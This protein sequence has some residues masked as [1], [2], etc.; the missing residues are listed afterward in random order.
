MIRIQRPT[1]SQWIVLWLG[2]IW[3]LGSL[4]VVDEYVARAAVGGL[5]VTL[6]LY[7]Q[8]S[9]WDESSAPTAA[10]DTS[11][12]SRAVPERVN[13]AEFLGDLLAVGFLS[14]G[15]G[16]KDTDIGRLTAGLSPELQEPAAS[17]INIYGCWL[18]RLAVREKYG[19]DF[20]Q[21]TW[22]AATRHVERHLG[23]VGQAERLRELARGVEM[24]DRASKSIGRKIGD[25]IVD[26]RPDIADLELP[27]AMPVAWSFLALSS[28]SPYEGE[29]EF[30]NSVDFQLAECLEAAR[31]AMLPTIRLLVEFDGP[32]SGTVEKAAQAFADA[33]HRAEAGAAAAGGDEELA[34]EW[35]DEPGPAERH[36]RRQQGNLLFPTERRIVSRAQLEVAQQQD[37]ASFRNL[38]EGLRATFEKVLG[39]PDSASMDQR[40]E[41]LDELDVLRVQCLAL[42]TA[43]AIRWLPD[44]D[45]SAAGT[46][47]AMRGS[48]AGSAEGSAAFDRWREHVRLRDEVS[49]NVA[50]IEIQQ[51]PTEDTVP[52][53]CSLDPDDI[54]L[55]L[56]TL[57]SDRTASES[58]RT[59]CADLFAKAVQEGFSPEKASA[60][61]RALGV[62]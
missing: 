46:L 2:A 43:D 10:A 12:T 56:R 6:L 27:F 17:W 5:I 35:S 1:R 21:A 54:A 19:E 53:V 47:D 55:L 20:A 41:A 49:H 33:V 60:R 23:G 45:S 4:A 42:A 40:K 61:L 58:L 37:Q 34:L 52:T 15:F 36:L 26:A 14:D 9:P 32:I 25:F 48:L 38:A 29:R 3:V 8:M 31:A 28:R 22:T 59:A 16:L 62:G 18:F 30:P 51:V 39:L 11:A 7:W 50:V 24:L 57:D 13:V 44:I